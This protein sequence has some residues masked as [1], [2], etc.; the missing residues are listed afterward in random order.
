MCHRK[1][2]PVTIVRWIVV[3]MS[4]FLMV[5]S[6]CMIYFILIDNVHRV[7]AT[8][9]VCVLTFLVVFS[10]IHWTK[11]AQAPK[12]NEPTKE[13]SERIYKDFEFFIKVFMALVGGIGYTKLKAATLTP[14]PDAKLVREAMQAVGALSMFTMLTL[15]LFIACHLGSKIR[16][17]MHGVEWRT[18]IFWQETWMIISMFCLATALWVVSFLW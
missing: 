14:P 16:R 9:P 12:Y 5:G 1:S 10:T 13:H 2:S 4:L 15:A 6:F 18:L 11:S 17:W 3:A 7:V 8:V